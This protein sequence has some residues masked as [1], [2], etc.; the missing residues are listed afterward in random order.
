MAKGKIGAFFADVKTHWNEPDRAKGNYVSYKE[1]LQIFGGVTFNYAAQVPLGY[2][3]FGAGCYLIMYHYSLPYI[4]F[5]V[6]SLIGL[7]LGYL[8]TL[9]GWLVTDNLNAMAKKTERRVLLIYGIGAAIGLAMLLT[10]VS[11]L[12]SKTGTLAGLIN[13]I[14]GVSL[15]SFFKILGVQ[16]FINGYGGLRGVFWRKKLLPKYG[17]YKYGLYANVVQK[18]IFIILIGWL[19][20]YKIPNVDERFWMAYLLFSLY[21]MFDFGNN[22]Q[23]AAYMASPNPQERLWIRAYPVKISHLLNSV[24]VVVIPL[25][26]RFD[27]LNF[28]RFVLPGTFIPIAALTFLFS[29]HVH[30]RIPQPPLEKKQDISL[31]YGISEV[32]RNKYRW[33][34]T[35]ADMLDAFGNGMLDIIT[36]VKL[37]TLRLSGLEYSL[38]TIFFTFRGTIPTFF[39]PMIMKRFSYRAL[40]EFNQIITIVATALCIV[41]L[42]KCGENVTLCA[43]ILY[44]T[45]WIRGFVQEVAKVAQQDMS[46]RLGD[47]QMYLSGE[48]LEGFSGV[49]GWFT[50][51]VTTII[52]LII[53]LILLTNGFNA[54]WDILFLDSARFNILAIPLIFDLAGH[55]MMMIPF[56][57]WRYN[58]RQHSYVMKTLEQRAELAQNGIYPAEYTGG[59]E[60]EDP[61]ELVDNLPVDIEGALERADT[62][63]EQELANIKMN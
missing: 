23:S 42:W 40:K 47:Y 21:G 35:I 2:I 38:L 28:F 63:S 3:G 56:A 1:Y 5:S 14:P 46:N 59:L 26:G 54:N 37:Y 61:G 13:N 41:A 43:V 52:G 60:F 12:L 31:W 39:A 15:R 19:P 48:R 29:R 9:I 11:T 18:S 30:E 27:D 10:D 36:I 25:L 45:M 62:M 7:P 32:M 20:I 58:N 8:W 34:N 17:R 16:F 33:V 24:F 53:P 6:V 49:Y 51:P 57:F 44:S 50:A 55:I 4:A 22:L